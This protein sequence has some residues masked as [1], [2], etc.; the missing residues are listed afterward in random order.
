MGEGRYARGW[1]CLAH[2]KA[3]AGQPLVEGLAGIAP[4]L[5]RWVVEFAFGE[6][7]SRPGL[8]LRTRELVTVAALTA[9]GNAPSQLRVHVAGALN[10]GA[11]REEV[12]EAILQMAVYAGFPAALNGITVAREVFEERDAAA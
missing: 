4:D 7:I 8:D 6:V 9:M 5:A 12:V 1:E 2:V 11:T 10:S 3:D